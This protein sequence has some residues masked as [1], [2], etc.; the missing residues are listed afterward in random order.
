MSNKGYE[1]KRKK[2]EIIKIAIIGRKIWNEW[3]GFDLMLRR[4]KMGEYTW[5]E[6]EK[7]L[8]EEVNIT[9]KFE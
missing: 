5:N 9:V 6:E 2:F 7:I 4:K 1:K 8:E 3:I